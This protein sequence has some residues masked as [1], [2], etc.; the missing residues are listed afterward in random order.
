MCA[1]FVSFIKG[2][3]IW[4]KAL[5]FWLWEKQGKVKAGSFCFGVFFKVLKC[6]HTV[7]DA[8]TTDAIDATTDNAAA[9]LD[10]TAAYA[11]DATDASDDDAIAIADVASIQ[12]QLSQSWR[13]HLILRELHEESP[14]SGSAPSDLPPSSP[15]TEI[16][17]YQRSSKLYVTGLGRG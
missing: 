6:W 7:D 16:I 5:E 2:I 11:V 3:G 13:Y 17:H 10:S 14:A 15:F 1:W 12:S 8:I 9:T 4:C